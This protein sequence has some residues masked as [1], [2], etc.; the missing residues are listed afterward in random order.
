MFKKKVLSKFLN[1]SKYTIDCQDSTESVNIPEILGGYRLEKSRKQLI[2]DFIKAFGKFQN[3]H[4]ALRKLDEDQRNSYLAEI[5]KQHIRELNFLPLEQSRVG[6]S[7]TGIREGEIDF[8]IEDFEGNQITFYEG[9]NLNSLD[10]SKIL[11]HLKKSLLNYDAI[12]LDEK[13]IGVYCETPNFSVL[14]DKYLRYLETIKICLKYIH[15]WF[16]N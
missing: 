1:N 8:T 9:F 3:K 12:G 15:Y 10:K 7:E 14:S 11:S 4:V 5:L 13:F 6:K 2:R 16:R